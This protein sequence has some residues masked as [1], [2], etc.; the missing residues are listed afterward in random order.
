MSASAES[1]CSVS[2]GINP[3]ASGIEGIS[4]TVLDSIV[5]EAM[6]KEMYLRLSKAKWIAI[7]GLM[8]RICVNNG[9]IYGGA[10]ISYIQRSLAAKDYYAFCKDNSINA[11]ENYC[12]QDVHLESFNNRNLFPTDIDVFMSETNF[13]KFMEH[14]GGEKKYN[15]KKKHSNDSYFFKSNELFMKALCLHKYECNI[16]HFSSSNLMSIIFDKKIDSSYF[17]LMIDIVVIKD[18][19]TRDHYQRTICERNILYPPF[20]KPDFDVNLLCLKLEDKDGINN[21]VIKPLPILKRLLNIGVDDRRDKH[22][23][24]FKPLDDYFLTKSIIEDIIAGIREKRIRP[25]YPILEE[26]QTVFGREKS[27]IIDNY[28]IIKMLAKNFTID[29]FNIIIE[30]R[31][32]NSIM[33]APTDYKYDDESISDSAKEKCVICYETFSAE[34]PWFKCCIECNCKMHQTCIT[35]YLQNIPDSNVGVNCPHCRR[36]ILQDN[37]PCKFIMFFN[38]L[39][40]AIV[41]NNVVNYRVPRCD[42][43]Y[44]LIS[45]NTIRSCKCHIINCRCNSTSVPIVN[46]ID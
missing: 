17:K 44:R 13:K 46:Q 9:I 15:F 10:V 39:D 23:N 45:G 7:T 11:D 16:I 36:E 14:G 18:E 41:S 6:K 2:E 27:I 1:S 43:C 21:F 38:T 19:Y 35:K 12:N 22:I 33:W 3:P 29:K 5:K 20:G 40:Y 8:H 28:R 34:K 24:S 31:L 26:Y 4:K 30:P 25:V 32:R 42:E 37:C